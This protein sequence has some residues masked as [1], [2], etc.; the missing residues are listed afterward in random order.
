MKLIRILIVMVLTSGLFAFSAI[1]AP[2]STNSPDNG[3]QQQKEG[4]FH[5][6]RKTGC[7]KK[8][9]DKCGDFK[10]CKDPIKSLEMKKQKIRKMQ[11]E[12]KITKEKA[13]EIISKID[14]RIKEIEEFNKL[15]LDQ[16]KAK[17]L[18]R[19][20]KSVDKRVEKGRITPEE[21][22]KMIR[23]YTEK[24]EKWDGNGYPRLHGRAAK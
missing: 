18:E 21:A 13:D 10:K 17:L 4:A 9:K 3:T 12:N 8:Y 24:I 5:K 15:P 7:E 23:E 2:N 1:A 22:D 11:E 6:G 19:F 16:K 20:K 14:T